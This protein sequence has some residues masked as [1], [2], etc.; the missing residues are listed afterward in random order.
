[1]QWLLKQ[2]II[3][4]KQLFA[5]SDG[6]DTCVEEIDRKTKN[7]WHRMAGK[8]RDAIRYKPWAETA[9]SGRKD[10]RTCPVR[11][12]TPTSIYRK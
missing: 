3:K 4:H 7:T 8:E 5:Y 6:V 12:V 9:Q 11:H 10:S 1:M 2:I